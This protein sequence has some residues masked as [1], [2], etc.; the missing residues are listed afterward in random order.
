[1]QS[2]LSHPDPTSPS[3]LFRPYS[4]FCLISSP[5]SFARALVRQQLTRTEQGGDRD[6]CEAATSEWNK[7]VVIR[8]KQPQQLADQGS[9]GRTAGT[10]SGENVS[11]GV[12]G[13]DAAADEDGE[14]SQERTMQLPVCS[15]HSSP[16]SDS[17]SLPYAT[18]SRC[19]Y[20]NTRNG[21]FMP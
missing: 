10:G 5:S 4:L 12:V 8:F 2:P 9:A 21:L 6:E 18:L 16:E 3:P 14:A 20:E 11:E 19:G 15:M 13:P 1:L 7:G 17:D